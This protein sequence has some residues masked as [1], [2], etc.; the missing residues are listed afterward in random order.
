MTGTIPYLQL[1]FRNR[2][3][4]Q[5]PSRNISKLTCHAALHPLTADGYVQ[6]CISSQM[7]QRPGTELSFIFDSREMPRWKFPS[8]WRKVEWPHWS[9]QQYLVWNFLALFWLFVSQTPYATNY[10]SRL[11]ARSSI[12]SQLL[13]YVGWSQLG[14]GFTPMLAVV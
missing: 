11:I 4:G 14:A 9:W 1:F 8:W 6:I 3:H 2:E 10:I 5:Y 13:F 12:Q 7:L